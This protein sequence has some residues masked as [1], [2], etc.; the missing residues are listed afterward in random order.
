M[1][2]ELAFLI[3]AVAWGYTF[4]AYLQMRRAFKLMELAFRTLYKTHTGKEPS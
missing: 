2:Y 1:S 4:M 3:L